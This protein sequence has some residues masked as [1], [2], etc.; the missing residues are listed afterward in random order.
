MIRKHRELAAAAMLFLL[1]AAPVE[2]NA[3]S[4]AKPPAAPS[5]RKVVLM[6]FVSAP[7]PR[8]EAFSDPNLVGNAA[9]IADVASQMASAFTNSSPPPTRSHTDPLS[10]RIAMA[11]ALPNPF[12]TRASVQ[13]RSMGMP[14]LNA[15]GSCDRPEYLPDYSHG[16]VVEARR[17]LIFPMVHQAA[18]EQG[19]PIGLFDALIMQESRYN[20]LAVSPKGALGLAQLMPGTARQLGT[21]PYTVMDNLRGGARYLR[22]QVDRFGRYDLALAAYNSGPE[23]VA[24][25]GRVPLIAETTG[26][27]RSIS[28]TW[29]GSGRVF[30]SSTSPAIRRIM[31]PWK[32]SSIPSRLNSPTNNDGRPARMPN[33]SC[34]RISNATITNGRSTLPSDIGPQNRPNDKWPKP[35]SI[36]AGHHQM[37][38][39][40]CYRTVNAIPLVGGL[41]WHSAPG[42]IA[43]DPIVTACARVCSVTCAQPT[44]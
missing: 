6:N 4:R 31:P 15:G 5:Q 43:D 34:S 2:L 28:A 30:A 26:Y 29:A 7:A 39:R 37:S 21:D 11:A 44:S 14:A 19:L 18:C 1:A 17:R 10:P 16:R 42:A 40:L 38:E 8:P 3:K 41:N 13:S 33:A 24:R 12:L 20:H 32:V 27:V 25:L 22:Q 9:P 35:V 36:K 23:R